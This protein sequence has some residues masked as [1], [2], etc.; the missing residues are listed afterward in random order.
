MVDRDDDLAIGIR[1]TAILFGDMD[2]TI[3]GL[4]QT[5]VIGLL[6]ALGANLQFGWPY[7][8]ALSVIS[9]LFVYQQWLIRAR[10][11]E[12]CFVAFLN[13]QWAGMV[14]FIGVLSQY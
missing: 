3:I 7:Y 10:E 14:L 1:S 2:R 6:I 5:L 13:N 12:G 11:R 8:L 9:G 4:L